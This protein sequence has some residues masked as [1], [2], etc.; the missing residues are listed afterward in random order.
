VSI[1][2]RKKWDQRYREGAYSRRDYPSEFLKQRLSQSKP[3][4]ALDLACGAGRNS[5]FLA[6]NGFCVDAVDVS[7]VGL[8]RARERAELLGV[9]VNWLNQDLL[10][11][12]KL[13]SERYSLIIMFRFVALDLLPVL[14][15][16][17]E[18]GGSL[19]IE[20]HL[21]WRDEIV[22]GPTNEKFRVAPGELTRI[23]DGLKVLYKYEG[24]VTEP[25]GG[26]AA[27]SQLHMVK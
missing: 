11:Q 7:S 4:K 18:V 17:L 1:A 20:E 24:L 6:Q 10:D 13:P 23:T 14:P 2:D 22:T 16:I 27:L 9:S 21:Q 8:E 19:I 15:E 12:W 26:L 3:G 25:D 5:I